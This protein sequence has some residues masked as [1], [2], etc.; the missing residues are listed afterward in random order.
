VF[1]TRAVR[2]VQSRNVPL[3]SVDSRL[4]GVVAV[5]HE[6]VLVGGSGGRASVLGVMPQAQDTELEVQSFVASL[7]AHDRIEL[8]KPKKRAFAAATGDGHTTHAIRTVG[9]KKVLK[10]IRFR[11][12][13][14]A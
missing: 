6:P 13:C 7:L 1:G 10:R 3:G 5:A 14:C 12:G 8:G 9:G 11:C 2:V 4:K